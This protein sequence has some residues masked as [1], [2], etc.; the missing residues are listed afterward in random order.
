[1]EKYKKENNDYK[2]K[3]EEYQEKIKECEDEFSKSQQIQNQMKNDLVL[4]QKLF[5]DK[6]EKQ[7]KEFEK[8]K[9][10]MESKIKNEYEKKLEEEKKKMDELLLLQIQ[11]KQ[12]ELE[13]NLEQKINQK[14]NELS[15]MQNIH[16]NKRLSSSFSQIIHQRIKC[17]MCFSEPI[18]GNRYK[19]SQCNNY[20]L[21]EN[22][23][24]ENSITEKH[25]HDFIKIRKEKGENN[26]NFNISKK[27]S[28]NSLNINELNEELNNSNNNI[29]NNDNNSD[30]EF[31]LIE[32]MDHKEI[33]SYE[34]LNINSLV[35][36]INEGEEEAKIKIIIKNDKDTTWPKGN[37]K[38]SIDFNS[39]IITNDI[40]LEAQNYNEIRNYNISFNGLEK[41]SPGE[42]KIYALFEVNGVKYGEKIKMKIIIKEKK[43]EDLIKVDKFRKEFNL[44]KNDYKD[45]VLLEVLKKS[46]FDFVLAF[47]YLYN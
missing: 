37:T 24:E 3:I 25:P 16:S 31:N 34:C 4:K 18:I 9:E 26:N 13:K 20:N 44:P 10:E 46:N 40:I 17:E 12:N 19:C 39:D 36:E 27:N 22:C 45:E 30:N 29:V 14:N 2:N 1:M 43:D 47:T 35:A 6:L 11:E 5:D 32:D 15:N 28:K 42:Y 8:I 7:K 38:L 23:E 41:N 33:Y 21:C